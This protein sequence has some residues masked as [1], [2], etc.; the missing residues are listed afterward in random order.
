MIKS[1][2][3]A[4]TFGHRQLIGPKVLPATQKRFQQPNLSYSRGEMPIKL[5]SEPFLSAIIRVSHPS[6]RSLPWK[7]TCIKDG[8]FFCARPA[9]SAEVEP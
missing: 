4:F 1:M 3:T 7:V 6:H 8:F 9:A 2:H 5:L